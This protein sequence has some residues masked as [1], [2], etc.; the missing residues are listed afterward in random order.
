MEQRL[1][2]TAVWNAWFKISSEN[3]VGIHLNVRRLLVTPAAR[4]GRIIR[5]KHLVW[6]MNKTN[7]SKNKIFLFYL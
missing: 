5:D 4:G 7:K 3:F 2:K 1:L 6:G